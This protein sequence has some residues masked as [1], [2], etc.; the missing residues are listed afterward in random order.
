MTRCG[1][2]D[3]PKP[4]GKVATLEMLVLD[5]NKLTELNKRVFKLKNLKVL[6]LR[7]NQLTSISENISVL[8]NLEVLDLRGN[9]FKEFDIAVLKA[10]LPKC[11][12]LN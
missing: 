5:D 12:V 6:S 7:N 9:T 1:L 11:R 3:V 2:T 4:V 8:Q 10:L